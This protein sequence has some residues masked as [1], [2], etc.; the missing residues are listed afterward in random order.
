LCREIEIKN[1]EINSWTGKYNTLTSEFE[2][3]KNLQQQ[4]QSEQ[5]QGL[6]TELSNHVETI[7]ALKA[8]LESKN[9]VIA[10]LNSS[11]SSKSAELG[12]TKS[13]IERLNNEISK[14]L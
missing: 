9:N 13:E 6:S 10:E 4:S 14:S 3:Y 7:N 12:Y 1:D 5:V 2:S 8:E 11:V